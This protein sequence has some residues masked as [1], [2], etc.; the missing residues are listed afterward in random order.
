MSD[1]GSSSDVQINKI[2]LPID[3]SDTSFKAARYAIKMASQN[4]ASIFCIYVIEIPTYGLYGS[5]GA[6]APTYYN[7]VVKSA[8]EWFEE[9]KEV[10]QKSGVKI[11]TESLMNA[12]SV[13]DSIVN[14]AAKNNIDIIVMGTRGRTGVKK[15]FLGSVASAVVSHAHC[16]VLVVR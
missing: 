14:Y 5:V 4:G 2:L 15:L 1:S 13:P 3:G 6:T 11:K 10:A 9:V 8:D 7:E 16:P 12:S